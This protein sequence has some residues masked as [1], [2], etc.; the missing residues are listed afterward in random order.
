MATP[1]P[2]QR[3]LLEG[4]VGLI[5]LAQ[6]TPMATPGPA[7]AGLPCRLKWELRQQQSRREGLPLTRL[8]SMLCIAGI[9]PATG[10]CLRLRP[11]REAPRCACNNLKHAHLLRNIFALGLRWRCGSDERT[12]LRRAAAASRVGAQPAPTQQR[13]LSAARLQGP[14]GPPRAAR[15]VM[16]RPGLR[17]RSGSSEN[18]SVS[19]RWRSSKSRWSISTWRAVA[20]SQVG[21]QLLPLCPTLPIH[22]IEASARG[23]G[24][25]V[26]LNGRHVCV[27]GW[28]GRPSSRAPE[29]LDTM[30][31]LQ[32][33]PLSRGPN[34]RRRVVRSGCVGHP[35]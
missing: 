5:W 19:P 31:T 12:S 35:E 11:A 7:M 27:C 17:R 32:P 34:I 18:R 4:Y 23:R 33:L 25:G 6:M 30:P 14:G 16:F 24:N 20:A 8:Q 28:G 1:A 2:K 26:F 3:C 21:A 9:L 15:L 29:W 10:P 13:R 22:G